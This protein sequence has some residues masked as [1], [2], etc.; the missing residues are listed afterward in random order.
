MLGGWTL[1]SGIRSHRATPYEDVVL[2]VGKFAQDKTG[3]LI[4]LERKTGLRTHAESGVSLDARLSYDLL[5]TIFRPGSRFHDGAV[6]IMKDRIAAASCF[7]PLSVTTDRTRELGS[8]HRAA[9]GI[10]EETD[11]V[12]LVVAEHTGVISLA[13]EGTL[14]PGLSE[15][16]VRER[17]AA[18]FGKRVVSQ[19]SP[20]GGIAIPPPLPEVRQASNISIIRRRDE[21]S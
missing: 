20:I 1:R 2:S 11:A 10:T 21:A 3:A 17:I 18:L 9:I 12:A 13:V 16:R 14:E 7:L 15:D 5:L 19:A 6:I 4:V 8:R